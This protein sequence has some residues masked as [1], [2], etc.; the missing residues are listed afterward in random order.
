MEEMGGN[1]LVG[2]TIF[3]SSEDV[4]IPV[5]HLVLSATLL[6]NTRSY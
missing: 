6:C 4:S 1:D 2:K 5:V 3:H